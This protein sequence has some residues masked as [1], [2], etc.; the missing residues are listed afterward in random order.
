MTKQVTINCINID[1]T[2]QVPTGS[3]LL[4][5]LKTINISA[6]YPIVVAMV[7]N[8]VESL[9]YEVYGNKTVQFCA[10]NTTP[11]WQ[12]YVRSLCFIMAKATNELMPDAQLAI[13]HSLSNGYYC[14]I[15]NKALT[16]EIIDKLRNKM[17]EYVSK[18]MSFVDNEI[19]TTKVIELFKKQGEDDKVLLLETVG[20]LY[21]KYYELD[22]FYDYFYSCLVPSTDYLKVFELSIYN[23]GLILHVPDK[24]NP[25]KLA[26][27]TD[28]PK[29]F[30]AY[31][32]Q[33]DF[34]EV[35]NVSNVGDL[36]QAILKNKSSQIIQVAEAM[37][38]R[39]I[40]NIASIISKRAAEKDLHVVMIAG[41]SSSGKTTFRMRLEIQLLVNLIRPIGLS[42]DDYFV[43]RVDT[44]KDETGDYD[45]ESLYA[46]DL[47]QFN[48]DLN[49]LMQGKKVHLPTYNFK[50]GEREYRE[51]H[52]L[53]LQ[54]GDVL[55]IEGIHGLNPE[56]TASIDSS[57]IFK[58]YISA[59]TTV[60]LD[61]HNWVS[62][63]DNRLLRRMI[64]DFKYRNYSPVDTISR[65]S[66][67]RDGENKWIF[68]YQE[69]A[70][71]TFNSAMIY[72]LAAMRENAEKILKQVPN[73][74]KEYAEAY[75]LLNLLSYFH[76]VEDKELPPT[77]LLRE[78]LG[79]SS[80][81][82]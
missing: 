77:S 69:N 45:Y 1:K 9:N 22:G 28:Q 34:L 14:R 36:N 40:S 57:K 4:E 54:K 46:L 6:T 41:P 15:G 31:K 81:K 12:A 44:P 51:G 29:L 42:L 13:E 76:Y 11:A 16:V 60:S 10:L 70:D 59:L 8:K 62:T 27:F 67:V 23:E 37:Q 63:A 65:W 5:V 68:P 39:E 79:G 30:E 26:V 7:N 80:F 64:R 50:T 78:F 33:L 56:L 82:Y 47:A 55:V 2:V 3:T 74:K 61:N 19:E 72:E 52:V 73:N 35:L 17:Q 53:Q 58:V 24:A 66:K 21:S 18:G 32:K 43:N 38:E 71:V 20:N 48:K 49:D 25:S 75:R